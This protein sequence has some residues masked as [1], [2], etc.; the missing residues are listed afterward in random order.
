MLYD[1]QQ[2][3]KNALRYNEPGSL[4]VRQAHLVTALATKAVTDATYDLVRSLLVPYPSPKSV[5]SLV[6]IMCITCR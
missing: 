5:R 1:L 2:L 6:G 4:I 3:A